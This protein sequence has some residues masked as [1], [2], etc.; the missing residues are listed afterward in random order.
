MKKCGALKVKAFRLITMIEVLEHLVNLKAALGKISRKLA[1]DGHL[2]LTTLDLHSVGARVKFLVTGKVRDL[3]NF[4]DPT[5]RYPGL[6]ANL[7]KLLPRSGLSIDEQWGY[8]A[9]GALLGT[10]QWLSIP[11]R[12][13][14]AG[15]PEEVPGD[16]LCILTG[17][18][19]ISGFTRSK[20]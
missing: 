9:N 7:D 12:V 4:G 11:L 8:P 14:K 1:D 20:P 6:L 13:L 18:T 15:V 17:K 3:N 10:R 19:S 2:L 5:H 16:V